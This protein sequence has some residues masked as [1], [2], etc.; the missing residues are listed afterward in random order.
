MN[1]LTEVFGEPASGK[2]YT[3]HNGFPNPLHLDTSTTQLSPSDFEVKTM[4]HGDRGESWSVIADIYDW[5]DDSIDEHYRYVTSFDDVYEMVE[6][7]G[8]EHDTV[9]IDNT[10]DL[11]AL[12]I[13]KFIADEGQKWIT[14]SQ[15][16]AVND[17]VDEVTQWVLNQGYHVVWIS[18]MKDEYADGDATGGRVVD[19][20][21][22]SEFRCDF[23]IRMAVEDGERHAYVEKNRLLDQ[24]GDNWVD[25]FGGSV[26]LEDL[27]MMAGVP[28]REWGFE[29]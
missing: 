6:A 24:A 23:R 20:P 15:Y 27:L 12:A 5:D 26:E 7:D 14:Q 10:S 8:G 2:T 29:V 19:G 11:K 18:Q 16:G 22:R 4:N 28:E 3:A 17:M 25:D 9:I 13:K 1:T 21:K